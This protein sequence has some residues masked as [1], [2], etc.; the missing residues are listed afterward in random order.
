MKQLNDAL[1]YRANSPPPHSAITLMQRFGKF[2]DNSVTALLRAT[3]PFVASRDGY[4]F[5]N[6]D[7]DGWPIT[8][9]DARVL[10]ERYHGLIDVVMPLGIGAVRTALAALSFPVV[11]GLPIAAIDFL[12]NKITED[13]RNQMLDN[14]VSSFPGRYGRCGGMAFSAY[15]FFLLGW[16]VASF[17]V[18]PSSGDLRQYIWNRLVDSL[19][20][21][22]AIFLEW[23]MILHILPIISRLTSAAL[24]A[25]AGGVIAGPLG[26]AVSAFVAGRDDAL[27]LGGPSALKDKSSDHL[28]RLGRH[29]AGAAAWPIGLVYGGSA[30]P[31]D[32]HQVLALACVDH[33]AGSYSLD[34]WDNNEKAV[35]RKLT[36]DTSGHDL[37][38]SSTIHQLRN[39][40]GIICE[41]YTFQT[42][43]DS[44]KRPNDSNQRS[45]WRLNG[46][47]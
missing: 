20:L 35:C 36:L 37:S 43:P 14:I 12:I 11:G 23:V 34:I 6:S 13:F 10:R 3:G 28:R 29:L 38:V 9:E 31:V 24:G 41:E 44:L 17:N 27:G 45:N 7:N 21:N 5:S 2:P 39:I 16:P 26:A 46:C 4:Q 40:K 1:T 22:A 33:G 25:A 8:E 42:P 30:N 18:Q 47:S 32:Q 15:D 19:E